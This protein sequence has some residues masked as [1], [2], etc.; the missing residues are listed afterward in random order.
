MKFIFR[1]ETEDTVYRNTENHCSFIIL[2]RK[3]LGYD[4]FLV[5]SGTLNYDRSSFDKA[6][7]TAKPASSLS[8]LFLPGSDRQ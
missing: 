5:L 1:L 2:K 7:V 8:V 4:E 3:P 6:V